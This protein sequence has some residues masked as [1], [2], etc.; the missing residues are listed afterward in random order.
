[1]SKTEIQK[2]AKRFVK[3]A[4]K[5][6]QHVSLGEVVRAGGKCYPQLVDHVMRFALIK[7]VR[8]ATP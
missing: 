8:L 2:L 3:T 6:Q 4:K 5:N 7:G 1:M